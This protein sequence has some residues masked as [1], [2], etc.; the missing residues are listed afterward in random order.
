MPPGVGAFV[1]LSSDSLGASVLVTGHLRDHAFIQPLQQ[2][3]N[4]LAPSA[5]LDMSPSTRGLTLSNG[6]LGDSDPTGADQ[7]QLWLGDLV[8]G[9]LGYRGYFLLEADGHEYWTG[10]TDPDL[11]DEDHST[12]FMGDR[13]FF[14]QATGESHRSYRVPAV[15]IQ[16]ER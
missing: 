3:Y 14:F 16:R 8:Q 7:V 2:G 12:L 4:L 1:R 9:I 13:A 6:F 15:E 10:A 11:T 5:P